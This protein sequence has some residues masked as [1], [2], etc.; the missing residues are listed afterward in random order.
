[1]GVQLQPAEASPPAWES[2]CGGA[3]R[4]QAHASCTGIQDMRQ[5]TLLQIDGFRFD[6]MG[7]LMLATMRKIQAALAELTLE[8]HGVDGRSVYIYGEGWDFGEACPG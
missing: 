1:M 7:H 3:L 8:Q 5:P 6:I 2:L 4:M